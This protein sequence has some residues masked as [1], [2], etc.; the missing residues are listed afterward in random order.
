MRGDQRSAGRAELQQL[1]KVDLALQHVECHAPIAVKRHGLV[2]IARD[3]AERADD[4]PPLENLM[5][6]EGR[7]MKFSEKMACPNDHTIDTDD[8]EPR[9]FSFNSPFGACSVCSGLGTRMEV[10]PELVVPDTGA[11]LTQGQVIGLMQEHARAGDTIVAAALN[12]R[13]NSGLRQFERLFAES[14]VKTL[15]NEYGSG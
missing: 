5:T 15:M 4:F 8:L 13:S 1:E 9:S 7:E 12:S 2:R 11:L 6:V 3:T 10:D 14:E